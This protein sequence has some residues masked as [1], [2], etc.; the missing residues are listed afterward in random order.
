MGQS[1]RVTIRQ[2][3]GLGLPA[4]ILLPSLLAALRDVVPS[5]HAA[6]FYCDDFGNIV[7]MYAERMLP[8]DAMAHY[9]KQHF[10][11]EASA[12]A[13]AY[14]KRVASAVPVSS[15]SVSEA[16]RNTDYYRDVLAPVGIGQML[17]A[18]VRHHEH[19]IGQLSLYREVEESAFN[20]A[21][22]GAL[23]DVLHYLGR[24]LAIAPQPPGHALA[25]QTA[26]QAM[27]ILDAQGHLQVHR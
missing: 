18:I 7:N 16:E 5:S 8:P 3:C 11:A 12:F 25:E 13:A 20:A 23:A 19:V 15:H 6:F 14:L 10:P 1:A 17:Y 27:A 22:E 26:E 4:P 9:H 21:D 24:A 2:L